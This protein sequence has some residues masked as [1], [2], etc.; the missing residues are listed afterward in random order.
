MPY[1]IT[2]RH[3]D[4]EAWALVKEDG[5]LVACHD[6]EDSATDQMV[7]V[8]LAEDLEPGGTYEG[9]S[10]RSLELRE[11]PDAYR[12]ANSDDVP[13]GRACGNCLFYREDKQNEE[14]L[15]YCDRWDDYVRGDYYCD[16]WEG[17]AEGEEVL[18]ERQV[19]L[20][21]PAYM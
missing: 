12:P 9:E 21:P 10:F 1:F 5:E 18:E 4:C 11:L 13:E 19:D 2:D 8:S 14:G 7:A 3:P 15:S 16:A 17:E 6:S 20:T